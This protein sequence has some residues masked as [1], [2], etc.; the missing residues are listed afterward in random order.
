MTI[1]PG[2]VQGKAAAP[3]CGAPAAWRLWV[4]ATRP[5]GPDSLDHAAFAQHGLA[6][7]GTAIL[8]FRGFHL[9]ASRPKKSQGLRP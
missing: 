3:P 8:R 2:S 1:G 6:M 5:T 7:A 4:G 9:N